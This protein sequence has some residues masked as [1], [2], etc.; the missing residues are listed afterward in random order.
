MEAANLLTARPARFVRARASTEVESRA[1]SA[2]PKAGFHT[3][4]STQTSLLRFYGVFLYKNSPR[5]EGCFVLNLHS[6]SFD[7]SI[8]I[9]HVRKSAHGNKKEEGP[10]EP[11]NN[12][13]QLE[14]A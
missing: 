14:Y 6:V 3:T 11:T 1:P 10:Q 8:L 5:F 9:C 13:Y 12:W 7:P 2:L 4:R